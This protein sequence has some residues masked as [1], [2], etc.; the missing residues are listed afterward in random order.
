MKSAWIILALGLL[1]VA[2]GLGCGPN[3][4]IEKG[5]DANLKISYKKTEA[6]KPPEGGSENFKV[7]P[8]AKRLGAPP[9]KK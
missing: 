7:N 6:G 2:L 8:N 1:L 3:K 4:G 9:P 5:D